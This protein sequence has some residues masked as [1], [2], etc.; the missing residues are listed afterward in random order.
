MT[1]YANIA[2]TST[3]WT[4]VT[5]ATDKIRWQAQ[6]GSVRLSTK[7]TPT[8]DTGVELKPGEVLDISAGLAVWYRGNGS[9]AV[10]VREAI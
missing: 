7:S 8:G 10:L 1:D 3:A 6:G 4:Q 9:A 2:V 5:A